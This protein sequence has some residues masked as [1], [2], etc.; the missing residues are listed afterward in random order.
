MNGRINE[1]DA[2]IYTHDVPSDLS[3]FLQTSQQNQ[4]CLHY[5]SLYGGV[6]IVINLHVHTVDREI[7]NGENFPICGIYIVDTTYI[8]T[9]VNYTAQVTV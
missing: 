5:H 1:R 8:R 6:T 7:F 2:Y 3:V 9:D 4:S